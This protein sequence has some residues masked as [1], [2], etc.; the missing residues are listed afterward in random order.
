LIPAA[1]IA[2]PGLIAGAAGGVVSIVRDAPD[3]TSTTQQAFVPPEMAGVTSLFRIGLPLVVSTLATLPVLF[4]RF[5][6]EN[7]SSLPAAA[8]R[9]V[10]GV[11]VL[12]FFVEVWVRRRDRWRRAFR[13]FIDEGRSYSRQQRSAV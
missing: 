11:C 9:G 12:I 13:R 3:P 1:I 5:A 4:V 10:V 2:I 6:V 8:L 7:D